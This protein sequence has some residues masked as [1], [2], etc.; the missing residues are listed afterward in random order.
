MFP[1]QFYNNWFHCWYCTTKKLS[2]TLTAFFFPS[3]WYSLLHYILCLLLHILKSSGLLD[4]RLNYQSKC[5]RLNTVRWI[6]VWLDIFSFQIFFALYSIYSISV[7]SISIIYGVSS[8]IYRHQYTNKKS[9][10][11]NCSHI[12]KFIVIPSECCFASL[13]SCVCQHIFSVLSKSFISVSQYLHDSDLI[14]SHKCNRDV[15]DWINW[16]EFHFWS[17]FKWFLLMSKHQGNATHG[18]SSWSRG[19]GSESLPLFVLTWSNE[20]SFA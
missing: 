11:K 7:A 9:I 4:R 10:L 20:N 13:L 17:I 12:N 6:S 18:N 8:S 15:K 19:M 5:P 1:F 16:I 3:F 14:S 2:I